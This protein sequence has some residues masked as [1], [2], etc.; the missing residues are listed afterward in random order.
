MG[1][2]ICGQISR[3]IDPITK[4]VVGFVLG[5][6]EGDLIAVEVIKVIGLKV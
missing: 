5:R 6:N 1:L 4:V 3:H 2:N